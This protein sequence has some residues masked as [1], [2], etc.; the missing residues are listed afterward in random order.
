MKQSV[1]SVF[2]SVQ[3][4][5]VNMA[6]DS[7]FTTQIND[8]H[9]AFNAST[10][11]YI[12]S[13]NFTARVIQLQDYP[14]SLL[15]FGVICCL[16]FTIIGIPGNII[17]IA[18]LL[19]S[20]K[21]RN[22]TTV[23]LINL[24]L[25]DLL[26]CSF[27]IPLFALTLLHKRWPYGQ[28]LCVVFAISSHSNAAVLLLTLIGITTNRYM[29]IVHPELYDKIYNIFTVTILIALIWILPFVLLAPTAARMW[30]TFNFDLRL[31]ECTIVTSDG[32]SNSY[33]YIFLFF[34]PA[35]IFVFCYARIFCTVRNSERTV[36]TIYGLPVL[37]RN[38]TPWYRKLNLCG[39]ENKS[40]DVLRK[41]SRRRMKKEVK[42]LRVIFL[43][44]LTFVMCYFP[45]S[46]VKIWQKEQ[47]LPALNILG[48]IGQYFSA[49]ANPIIYV[50][51]SGEYRK[52]YSNLCVCC[53][54][55][56]NTVSVTSYSYRK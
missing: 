29:L 42:L 43:I 51:I 25:A 36:S 34:L 12:A 38:K 41:R 17:T 16:T 19:K 28:M 2:S 14:P 22:Y 30:D 8:S 54:E 1:N 48:H 37:K 6:D 11:E 32:T 15:Y 4:L 40:N 23:F 9:E 45:I 26:Y 27:T 55:P 21:F 44:F 49:C 33:V 46:L 53:Y 18:A 5:N 50:V 52:A 31:G 10:D 35:A 7:L 47:C 13:I 20:P 24:C 39:G 3:S 56:K